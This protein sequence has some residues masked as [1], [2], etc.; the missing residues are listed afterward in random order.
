MSEAGLRASSR[1][2]K[3][4]VFWRPAGVVS[5]TVYT[6]LA[7]RVP[8]GMVKLLAQPAQLLRPVVTTVAAQPLKRLF[9]ATLALEAAGIRRPPSLP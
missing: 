5:I 8:A 2:V 1:T 4:I 7:G 9:T 6:P 3:V